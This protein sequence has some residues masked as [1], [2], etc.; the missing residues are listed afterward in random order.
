MKTMVLLNC[1]YG[2]MIIVLL[3]CSICFSRAAITNHELAFPGAEGGGKYAT[4]GRGGK[5]YVV[6]S[7]GDENVPG[8][9]RY[10]ILQKGARII[11]FNVSG[12]IHLTSKLNVKNGDLTIAGQTAP[13]DGICVANYPFSVSASNVIIRYMRFRMGDDAGATLGDGAD[14]IG[15]RKQS[16][17]I[18]DHCSVSWSTDECASFYDNENFTMQWCIISESLRLSA[19]S[20]GP[21]GYGAIWG[22]VNASYH[23]NLLAHHDS[24]T[25]RFGPGA[26]YAGKD[27]VD[28]RNNVFYNWN[29]NGCYGS[30]AMSINVVNNYYKKGPATS[31]KV[32]KQLISVSVKTRPDDFPEI[33]LKAGK[34]YVTG[35]YLPH[36]PEVTANNWLG[37][38]N[39][40]EGH[41][42]DEQIYSDKPIETEPITIIH[43][44]Q[45]AYERVL[46]YAGCVKMRDALDCRIVEETRKGIASFKGLS[47]HNGDPKWKSKNHPLP[48]IIDSHWDIRP[49]DA[50]AEWTPWP[51]LKSISPLLDSDNDGMPDEW[52]IRNGLDPH[53]PDANGRNLNK[54]YD[55]IE[56]YFNGLVQEIT[57][58]QSK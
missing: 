49:S 50:S 27:R 20:K 14:A 9:L 24:R 31:K 22:G 12:T 17:V 7:L 23:H 5:V 39:S 29:G 11:V 47:P 35:N 33:H 41:Y 6:N 37:V 56:V 55:N 51:I 10:A 53:T 54:L 16:N 38:R 13:G 18:I 58:E 44:A 8:T 43:T 45:E 19:H 57:N 28:L 34:Y 52:E 42:T 21:H 46:D 3:F 2:L 48:G 32:E 40:T 26:K 25:P 30:E 4:G 1:K 15:G 36:S